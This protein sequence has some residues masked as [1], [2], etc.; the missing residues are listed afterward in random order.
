MTYCQDDPRSNTT[1]QRLAWGCVRFV[2]CVTVPLAILWAVTTPLDPWWFVA[3]AVAS[4]LGGALYRLTA[5]REFDR[6]RRMREAEDLIIR[7][8][9]PLHQIRFDLSPFVRK[10]NACGE[11]GLPITACN[12]LASYRL[13]AQHIDRGRIQEAKYA[14]ASAREFEAE[15]D[16]LRRE[17]G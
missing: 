3:I 11:C 8:S 10:V 12:A 17:E 13:A 9:L 7:E 16:C 1:G 14:I 15:F 6:Q 2:L 5:G 4:A